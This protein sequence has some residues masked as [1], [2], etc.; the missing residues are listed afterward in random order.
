M[1]TNKLTVE[2]WHMIFSK[3][4][5][6][7]NNPR[8]AEVDK[9]QPLSSRTLSLPNG[10]K[11]SGVGSREGGVS[12]ETTLSEGIR[13]RIRRSCSSARWSPRSDT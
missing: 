7:S 9:S 8:A 4:C 10:R 3:V 12:A 1:Q 13:R 2:L 6:S 11:E 5:L